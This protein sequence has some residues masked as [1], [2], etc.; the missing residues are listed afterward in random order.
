MENK[1]SRKQHKEEVLAFLRKHISHQDW[2]IMLPPYGTGHETYFV[3]DGGQSCFV[4]LGTETG[5]YQIMADLGLAPRVIICGDLADGTSILVQQRVDGTMPSRSDFHRFL[6]QFA[7]SLRA[8]HQCQALMTLLPQQVSPC[9]K[10][11]GLQT[12]AEI[13]A[14]WKTHEQQVPAYAAE[15]NESI[16]FLRSR[17]EKFTGSGLVAS[18]NDVCNGNW[19]VTPDERLY[20]LD[21]DSMSLDD[22]AL[23]LGAIL[24]WYYPPEMRGE[25]LKYAGCPDDAPFR[26]RMRIRMA[27]HNLNIILPR[28]KSFDRLTIERFEDVLEDFRAVM[29]DEENPKGYDD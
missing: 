4:K 24:W 11:A 26:H 3:T 12:L 10:D 29:N 13:E 8:I 17:V 1:R 18:H 6:R 9:F 20:M 28:H 5:R 25:F 14:R 16:A 7:E 15:I 22:P 2:E 21:F 19:L 23:D 27:I